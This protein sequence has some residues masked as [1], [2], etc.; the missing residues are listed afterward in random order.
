MRGAFGL[1]Q[2]N[3]K[4]KAVR[5]Y[6]CSSIFSKKEFVNARRIW[7]KNHYRNLNCTNSRLKFCSRLIVSVALKQCAVFNGFFHD[8]HNAQILKAGGKPELKG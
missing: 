2:K 1:N 4:F 6:S 5:I 3:Q 7:A 8:F